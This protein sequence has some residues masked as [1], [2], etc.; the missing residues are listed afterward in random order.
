VTGTRPTTLA[1]D[2]RE[3]LLQRRADRAR[4]LA[5]A[6]EVILLGHDDDEAGI[7]LDWQPDHYRNLPGVRRVH[8][9]SE[10]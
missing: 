7:Q 4:E 9:E 5:H 8:R 3:E 10:D 6:A 2:R 1:A